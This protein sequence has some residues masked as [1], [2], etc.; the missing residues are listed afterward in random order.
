MHAFCA[1]VKKEKEK[2]NKCDCPFHLF[3][4]L[5][6]PLSSLAWFACMDSKVDFHSPSLHPSTAKNHQHVPWEKTIN[7]EAQL[8][9]AEEEDTAADEAE[10]VEVVEE[11]E[12]AE[13]GMSTTTETGMNQRVADLCGALIV[14]IRP[15]SLT[16]DS[17]VCVTRDTGAESAL[18]MDR[19]DDQSGKDFLLT[20]GL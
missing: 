9:A 11:E 2:I 13:K 1:F 8:E 15:L 7:E 3:D 12:E 14:L 17:Y 10:V 18:D 4:T 16:I 20:T 6:R 19:G 5:N